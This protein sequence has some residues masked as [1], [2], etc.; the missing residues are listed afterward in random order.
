MKVSLYPPRRKGG[1][2]LSSTYLL[3]ILV[4]AI[5][6]VAV[7]P[8]HECAHG[9][10]ASWMG[11]H[12]AR[13]LG[14]N[15]L[16]PFAHLDPFGSTML[17]LTGLGWA[18]PVPIDPRNFRSPK[19]GMAVTALAGPAANILLAWVVLA[20]YKIFAPWIWRSEPLT[21]IFAIIIQNT[22]HLAVFN[23]IPIPPLDG[24]RLLTALLPDRLYYTVMR[25]ERVI[26][27]V[28][29]LALF[30]GILNFPLR[31]ITAGILFVL[32]K[33]TFFLR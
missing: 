1:P 13:D 21:F 8:I 10:V 18:R 30:T 25:Y 22:I 14:R 28:L 2:P 11:D 33:L 9:L 3:E 17:L 4:R 20:V 5:I 32:D 15:T 31:G 6:L 7:I 26:M 24:S 29:M 12:T 27:A 19:W 16:N 23:L